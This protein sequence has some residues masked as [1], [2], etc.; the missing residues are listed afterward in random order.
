MAFHD[1]I[2]LM[3]DYIGRNDKVDEQ[4]D[5]QLS[6]MVVKG[7]KSIKE[8]DLELKNINVLIGSNGAGK[9]NF[10]SVFEMLQKIMIGEL[11]IYAEKKGINALLY[12]GKKVTDSILVEIHSGSTAYSFE[13]ECTENDSLLFREERIGTNSGASRHSGHRESILSYALYVDVIK[14]LANLMKESTERFLINP[15][16]RIFQFHDTSQSSRIKSEH[17]ISN[18]NTLM[19]DASNLAAYLY[20]LR[21]HYSLEY[22]KIVKAIQRIAPYFKDFELKPKELNDEQIVLRWTQ[23]D[24]DGILNPSQL[25]DGTLRFICLATLLLQPAELQPA[26]II[27]DE[28]ELG[29]HP[30]A[31][32]IFAE[33]VKK[34]ATKKQVILATQSVELLDHFEPE[35]IIVVD[36]GDNGSEFKRLDVEQLAAWLDDYSLGELWNKNIFGGRVSR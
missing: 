9:S 5:G 10:V 3:D 12:N 22:R 36:R 27:I 33:L 8:C 32:T 23:K 34:A 35:D 11:S 15:P 25:S 20:R 28:P 6:R 24:Y 13:L 21:E 30:Y 16:W 4:R 14:G 26:T 29:L 1:I 19:Q 17:N 7:F 2:A 18:C 31:I